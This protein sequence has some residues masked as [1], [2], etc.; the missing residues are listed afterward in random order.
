MAAA[1]AR[2]HRM[3]FVVQVAADPAQGADPK[4]ALDALRRHVV[5]ADPG[6]D[7]TAE[8]LQRLNNQYRILTGGASGTAPAAPRGR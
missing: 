3:N 2:R 7:I 8:V 5:W 1:V 4:T 6:V